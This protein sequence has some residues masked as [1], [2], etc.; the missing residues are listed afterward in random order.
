MI[1][2]KGI[3]DIVSYV[4]QQGD[5]NLEYFSANRAQYGTKAHQA[6]QERYLEEECEVYVEG[7]YAIGEHEFHLNG[8]VDL[9]LEREGQWIVGEIK[10]T[11]RPLDAIIPGDRSTHLAQAKVYAY[12]LLCEHPEWEQVLVRLI[13]CDLEGVQTRQIDE[14]YTKEELEPFMEQTLQ[15]YL[16]WYLILVRSMT[17]KLKSAKSFTFPFGDFRSYQRELSASVYHCIKERKQLLLR[18]PTGIGK[19]MG[20][21]F[22][23]IKALS[24]QEQKIFYLTAKTI[25]RQV[26][27]KAFDVCLATG[28]VAKVTTITAK[29]KICLMEE[30]KCDPTYCPY[31]KGYFDRINE[32]VKDLFETEQLFNRDRLVA[33]AKKHQVCPFEYSLAMASISDAIIGDYNYMF[34]PRA[35]LRRFFDEPSPHI[36]LIDE[37]HNLYDRACEMYS[38]SLTKGKVQEL[39]RLFK[40]KSKSLNKA[41]NALNLKLLEYRQ[42]LEED[43]KQEI[44]KEE[45]ESSFL[46]KVMALLEGLEKYLYAHP[47]TEY[48]PQ[49]MDLYFECHQFLRISDFYNECFRV[50]YERMGIDL[51]ISLIC[52]NPSLYLYDRMQHVRSTILFSATLHPLSYY[53]TVLLHDEACE[54]IFLP[55]PFERENLDLYVHY[56][57]STKYKQREASLSKLV[58]TIFQVTRQRKG[59]YF[60]F[61]PSYQYLEQVF[62]GYKSLVGEE[63]VVI[64]QEREMDEHDREVFLAHFEAQ[65]EKTLVAFAVLGGIF[66]EGI[67]LIGD[68]LIGSVIVGVGLPQLNPLTE[69]RRL[70]FEETF[71]KGYLYAYLYPGFN[72]VMQAVGR[73]IRSDTDRGIVVLIDER[74]VE[75]TYLS[76]FP[77]EWQH[78][79]FLK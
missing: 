74:Y 65:S 53:Q 8:R 51:K 68:R 37:A 29:E 62:E 78:A 45:V 72:K 3:K 79:K 27:E 39:K 30:V 24:D 47:T 57:I 36:A 21:I 75:P 34:D 66:S 55:S 61:F 60:I 73:V 71:Q 59:N 4:Y 9:L 42:E 33:Y 12:L 58:F 49:L 25:G 67:D 28:W 76:L 20:T 40:G 43:K 69:Q 64:A 11:T 16:K 2:K 22:P 70:Y 18:A 35:Y 10:S 50:R 14:M 26:A 19:T 41:L 31:A 17:L 15:I 23:S 52:L 63:Q 77:Y 6:I 38:A 48:K 44:F 1:I 56:G 46:T 54:Q 7:R 32:A 13:Y 5:L